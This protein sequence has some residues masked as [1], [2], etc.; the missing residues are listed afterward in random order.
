MVNGF[1][2]LFEELLKKTKP[3]LYIEIRGRETLI[4]EGYCRIE[5]Y[6]DFDIVLASD[7]GKISVFGEGLRLRH[8][9]TECMA[10]EG[11]VDRVEFI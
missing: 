3:Q 9:S 2:K 5:V 1:M 4:A 11:R 7:N 6:S 8:L 10:I